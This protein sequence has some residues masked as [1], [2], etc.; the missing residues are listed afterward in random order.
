MD[1][2]YL[3]LNLFDDRMHAHVKSFQATFGNLL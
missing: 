1:I 3:C 2:G